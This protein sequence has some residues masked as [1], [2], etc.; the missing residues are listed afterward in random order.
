V[1]SRHPPLSDAAGTRGHFAQLH[2]D[3]RARCT[4]P[5]QFHTIPRAALRNGCC[6]E[7]TVS[8]CASAPVF[9]CLP[10]SASR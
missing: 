1:G 3:P 9:S 5:S 6:T 7:R 2:A 8:P 10:S 4:I